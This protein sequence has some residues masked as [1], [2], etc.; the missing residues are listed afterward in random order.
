MSRF[1]NA[2]TSPRNFG[3]IDVA[4]GIFSGSGT[5]QRIMDVEA[6][7]AKVEADLGIIPQEAAREIQKKA[8]V[9]LLDEESYEKHRKATGHS[10][11]GLLRAFKEICE[12]NAGQ[13]IHYGTTTQD[14]N[15]TAIVLQ[16]RDTLDLAEKKLVRLAKIIREMAVRHRSTVMIGRTNDQQALPITLGYKFAMWL[17]ELL[18]D[19]DRIR[20]CR[21]RIL[22]GQFG[23]AVGT[24]DSLGEIGLSVRDGLMAELNIGVSPIAWYTSR[25]RYAEYTSILSILCCTL[26]KLG[27]DVYI[28]QKT[29]VNELAEGFDPEKIGS[30]TMP[31]KRN[32][33]V[34]AKLAGFGRMARSITAD[35]LLVMEGTNER[36]T[37][38]LR[39]EPYFLERISTLADAALDTAIDLFGHLEIRTVEME[40]NLHCLG[41]LIY[42]EALMME[43]SKTLGRMEAHD[44]IHTLA[45]K[46]MGAA[47]SFIELLL[48]DE[49]VSKHL[50]RDT[51]LKIMNPK[52]HIGLAEHFVDVVT[53]RIIE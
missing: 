32:P 21:P 31:H 34:P 20:S 53:G 44:R 15:D 35:S 5:L 10:L 24:M 4:E 25:D 37:R 50:T 28:G 17:D 41:G 40:K 22:V 42:S 2:G 9:Q 8:H 48:N 43:L 14:I 45:Q 49:V 18:R 1:E 16:M 26:G 51:I 12:N 19:L 38:C 6:A 33:F 27:N 30:S 52:S 13:Y 46:A 36:D 7:L 11:M 39:V 23:G 3:S 29:E 47:G